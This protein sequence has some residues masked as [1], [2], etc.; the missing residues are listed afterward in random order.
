MKR[1]GAIS[2]LRAR[3]LP[4]SRHTGLLDSL[5]AN[6]IKGACVFP[7]RPRPTCRSTGRIH[8]SDFRQHASLAN[9]SRF[10]NRSSLVKTAVL[11]S[12]RVMVLSAVSTSCRNIWSGPGRGH[13]KVHNGLT[14]DHVPTGWPRNCLHPRPG[15]TQVFVNCE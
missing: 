1:F 14:L 7:S 10:S 15:A 4:M 6:E 12:A 3:L 13:C 11:S 9:G 8:I 2:G 5:P